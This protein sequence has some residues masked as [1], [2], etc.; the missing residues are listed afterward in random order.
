MIAQCSRIPRHDNIVIAS[1]PSV[2]A[3]SNGL[4]L[5]WIERGD[6][7][8]QL[9]VELYR[10]APQTRQRGIDSQNRHTEIDGLGR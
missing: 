2:M 1:E 3:V 9:I 10:L 5:V 7:P 4:W 6:G 8:F